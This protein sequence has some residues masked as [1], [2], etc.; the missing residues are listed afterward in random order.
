MS[1]V[2]PVPTIPD[3]ER[4]PSMHRAVLREGGE[5]EIYLRCAKTDSHPGK[6]HSSWMKD[7]TDDNESG[8]L[9]VDWDDE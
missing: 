9:E 4:C 8:W 1:R 5:R 6:N 2:K 7:W 3:E